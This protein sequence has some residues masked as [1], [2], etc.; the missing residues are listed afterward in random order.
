ML[1][2]TLVSVLLGGPSLAL[3]ILSQ[4]ELW[5]RKEYRWDRMRSYLRGPEGRAYLR[6]WLASA[7]LL[8][9]A[10]WLAYLWRQETWAR[11]FGLV[12]IACFAMYFVER[13]RRRGIFRPV[14]TGKAGLVLAGVGLVS[15]I[16]LQRIVAAQEQLALQLATF[17]MLLPVVTA[18][19][20]GVVNLAATARKR[21]IITEAAALR[22]KAKNLSVIG[23]TGSYGKTSTKHFLQQLL[24][25]SVAT[26]EHV[27]SEIGV[28]QDMMRKGEK[29]DVYVAE[30]GAYRPG[31]IAALARLTKPKIGVIT[32]IG[33]QHLDLFGS[34]E[35]ILQAKWELI[36][37]LGPEGVAVLN[38]DDRLL[39]KK[40]KDFEGKIIWFGGDGEV[41]ASNIQVDPHQIVCTLHIGSEGQTVTMPLAS[42]GLLA[43]V[44]TAAAA[45]RAAGVPTA[46]IFARVQSLK[47]LARTMEIRQG[48]A[49]AIII[50]DSYSA[51]ETG[52][53]NAIEH[54]KLFP[55][56]DKRIVMVPLIELSGEAVAVH[57]RLGKALADSRARVF[58]Y[59]QA[60]EEELRQPVWSDARQLARAVSKDLGKESVV[61]LEGRI[62]E[63]VRQSLL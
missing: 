58:V 3:A 6:S 51:N 9:D 31:E 23:I 41:R 26:P 61:L 7:A 37:G 44:L 16:C 12:A 11:W 29:K 4:V 39:V 52:V 54:I 62:P 33:N 36:E 32:A 56:Q 49:G 22:Q 60:F 45:A 59:G 20:V 40:A 5:Q 27:N 42:R 63:I 17:I 47:P 25:G 35:R 8:T 46:E 15:L 21:Q 18:G 48:R 38:A 13:A 34:P 50:D 19:A 24:P 53:H 30:M 55:H 2:E 28:A 57:Q 43:S 10:G 1:A 14:L